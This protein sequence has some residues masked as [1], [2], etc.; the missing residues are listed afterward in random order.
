M[1]GGGTAPEWVSVTP[2]GN[3]E[4]IA[5]DPIWNAA[6]DMVYGTGAD[7]GGLL[8]AGASGNVLQMNNGATAPE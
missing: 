6:G 5:S 8:S 1:D 7:T 3:G 2:G 4:Y